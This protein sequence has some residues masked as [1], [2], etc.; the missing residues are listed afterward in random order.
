M[1]T[2]TLVEALNKLYEVDRFLSRRASATQPHGPAS[3]TAIAALERRVGFKLPPSYKRFL[4]QTDGWEHFWINFTLAGT[5]GAH[6][7]RVEKEA[8]K[9]IAWQKE[10]LIEEGVKT[11]ADIK[12]WEK[13]YKHQLY[14]PNHWIVGANFAGDLYVFDKRTRQ[15][16]GEMSLYYWNMAYG[17]SQ[18]FHSGFD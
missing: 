7:R 2:M 5:G 14:L 4:S 16:N 6:S 10:R 17:V 1:A 11:P 18:M 3:P 15:P 8:K 9:I 12:R 13:E